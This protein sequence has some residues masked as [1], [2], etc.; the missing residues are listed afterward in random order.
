MFVVWCVGMV[1]VVSSYLTIHSFSSSFYFLSAVNKYTDWLTVLDGQVQGELVAHRC[2][3][4]LPFYLTELRKAGK[5]CYDSSCWFNRFLV[6]TVI[7]EIL[8]LLTIL[9]L[10]IAETFL[11]PA[12][13]SNL[14]TRLSCYVAEI[15]RIFSTKS[16]EW[17]GHAVVA[18]L[19]SFGWIAVLLLAAKIHQNAP[20]YQVA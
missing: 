10:E 3:V 13:L 12:A 16:T 19:A 11:L 4:E 9:H 6:L 7:R 17:M 14:N 5:S 15:C 2:P 1:L 20:T 18:I 8:T